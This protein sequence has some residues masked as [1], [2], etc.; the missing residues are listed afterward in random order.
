MHWTDEVRIATP[1][2]IDLDLELAGLG[3]R[4]VARFSDWLV[5]G[6]FT[7]LIVIA[8]SL[9]AGL[10]GTM[11]NVDVKS[12]SPTGVAL[13]LGAVYILWLA[14]EIVFEVS[15]N[16]QTPGKRMAGIRVL[17]EGGAPV[18]FRSSGIRNLLGLAD[19]L[20]AFYL[21]GA[22]LILSTVRRQRLG[23]IAA[24]TIVVRERVVNAPAETLPLVERLVRPEIAF[25]AEQLRRC[26]A[27]DLHVLRSFLQRADDMAPAN[28]KQLAERLAKDFLIKTGYRPE[29]PSAHMLDPVA[30]LASLYRDLE[31]HRRGGL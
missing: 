26:A 15:F 18:D 17:R 22:V 16:G 2:Q 10:L 8:V 3:S 23:D 14:Y 29:S 4:F 12:M 21:L 31:A 27:A 13:L 1:E 6:L 30:F 28:W 11:D 25:N 7:L 24:G 19:Y 9:L 5:K 20:P